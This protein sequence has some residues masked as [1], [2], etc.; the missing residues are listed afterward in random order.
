MFAERRGAPRYEIS[1]IGQMTADSLKYPIDCIVRN[2]STSGALLVVSAPQAIPSHF[3]L[4][5]AGSVHQRA[6]EVKRRAADSLGVQFLDG[7]SASG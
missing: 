6:C 3:R 4:S 2:I 7:S 1:R 5:I